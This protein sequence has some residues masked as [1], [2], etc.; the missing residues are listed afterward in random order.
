MNKSATISLVALFSIALL[1]V[2]AAH[3]NGSA[4]A[5]SSSTF[6]GGKKPPKADN[7]KVLVMVKNIP[8]GTKDLKAFLQIE[9]QKTVSKT[10]SMNGTNE[11]SAAIMFNKLN[12]SKGDG[13][14]VTVND[15]IGEGVIKDLKKPNKVTVSLS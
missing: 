4:I 13:F 10:V 3:F 7:A 2:S 1:G 15:H 12:A 14:A 11:S 8:T 5:A 6:L 9:T